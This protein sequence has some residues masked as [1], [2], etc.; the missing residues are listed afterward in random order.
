MRLNSSAST[1]LKAAPGQHQH[2]PA[3][4]ERLE[5][6]LVLELEPADQPLAL[7][8]LAVLVGDRRPLVLGLLGHGRRWCSSR[9]SCGSAPEIVVGV[10]VS[11]VALRLRCL[12]SS[13]TRAR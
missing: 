5:D 7:R 3:E 12:R 8:A 10:V 11:V 13:R 2:D 1:T 9:R 6:A 4:R